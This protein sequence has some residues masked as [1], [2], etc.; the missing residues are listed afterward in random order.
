MLKRKVK[1]NAVTNLTDA[2]YFAAWEVDWMGFCLAEGEEGYVAPA[3]VAAM[4]EWLDGLQFI[5]EFGMQN[6]EEIKQ[7]ASDLNLKAVQLPFLSG[8]DVAMGLN[9]LT[10][11][12]EIVFD[13]DLDLEFIKQ[14]LEQFEGHVDY[15]VFD[16]SK[17]QIE[18]SQIIQNEAFHSFLK[19]N[20]ANQKV[21]MFGNF[22]QEEWD[23]IFENFQPEGMCLKGGDEEKV[24]Y[25]SFDELDEVF[26]EL[27]VEQ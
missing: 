19:E 6:A 1:I 4:V 12:K 27:F 8:V 3:M 25:K 24:G 10:V 21:W 18:L 15:F 20:C 22:S 14:I 16:F 13:E 9:D 26:E 5:G 17:N 2:R 7:V 11:F 23:I